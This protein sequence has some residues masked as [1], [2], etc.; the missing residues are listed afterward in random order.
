MYEK[1]GFDPETDAALSELIRLLK[2]IPKNAVTMLNVPKYAEVIRSANQIVKFVKEDYPDVEASLEFDELTGT[3]L[4]LTIVSDGV[5]IYAIK[6]FCKALSV[7]STMDVIPLSDGRI[8][9]GF[10]YNEVKLPVPPTKPY[11]GSMSL[12]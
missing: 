10:T 11:N 2:K 9:I 7:A 6:D 4:L 1:N 8:Q 12:Q 5:N 3:T